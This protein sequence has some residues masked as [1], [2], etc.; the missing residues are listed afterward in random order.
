MKGY[1]IDMGQYIGTVMYFKM[2]KKT[3]WIFENV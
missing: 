1:A 2:A 3:V